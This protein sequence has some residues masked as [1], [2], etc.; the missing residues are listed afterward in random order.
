MNAV[1]H[2][3]G[4]RAEFTTKTRGY[5]FLCSV[6]L[7]YASIQTI[8]GGLHAR[9]NITASDELGDHRVEFSQ[10]SI[11]VLN[12]WARTFIQSNQHESSWDIQ[13]QELGL[14]CQA[15]RRKDDT[16]AKLHY[17]LQHYKS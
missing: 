13:L 14:L 8:Y 9:G 16:N 12:W 5:S 17:R 7:L 15:C 3:S 6:H 2:P 4:L 11:L 10:L 1:F